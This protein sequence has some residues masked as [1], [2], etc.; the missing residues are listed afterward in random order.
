MKWPDVSLIPS[1]SSTPATVDERAVQATDDVMPPASFDG[2]GT[3]S[4]VQQLPTESLQSPGIQT[5][6]DV[7]TDVQTCELVTSLLN[8]QERE[9][10]RNVLSLPRDN[11]CS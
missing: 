10:I 11:L 2:R 8:E 1:P 5:S 4:Q 9:F 7:D 6:M 3:D